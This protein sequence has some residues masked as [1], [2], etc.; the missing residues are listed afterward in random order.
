MKKAFVTG[1][2]GFVGGNLTRRLIREGIEFV[3]YDMTDG[4]SLSD[5]GRM[6][7]LMA[8]C[9]FV[10]HLAANADI[11]NGW[12]HP[13]RD[14]ESNTIGTSNVLEA[15]RASGVKRIGFSSSSAVYGDAIN[16]AEDCP[17]PLQ[18]NL[19]GAS[20]VA[21][22][23]LIQAYAEGQ[24]FEPYIFR[25]V[26]ILGE[27]YLHGHVYDFVKQLISDPTRL[28]VFGNGL[29]RKGYF[30]A[31][32]C[33]DAMFHLIGRKDTGIWNLCL[34]ETL[35]VNDSI[36]IITRV[37]GVSPKIVYSGGERGWV[38]DAPNLNPSNRKL[39]ASGFVP[40]VGAEEAMV[41]TVEWMLAHKEI[42]K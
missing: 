11:R 19:Y 4:Q 24:G 35:A 42:F 23:S 31:G 41:R 26:P 6:S 38:G 9:D 34:D 28:N 30:Y 16:P 10:F 22:E 5:V 39:L 14:L 21:G 18:T 13:C 15:M 37:M 8:G 3:G 36:K 32:D 7:A 1:F 12:K 29:Q 17:W 20:K 33:V 25:F 27:G 40:K 2:R